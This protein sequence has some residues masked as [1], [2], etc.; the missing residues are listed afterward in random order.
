MRLLH[1]PLLVARAGGT[2]AE[3][4]LDALATHDGYFSVLVPLPATP[5]DVALPFGREHA[6]LQ[7]HS[8]TMVPI[9]EGRAMERHEADAM[10]LLMADGVVDH[11]AGL[12]NFEHENAMLMFPTESFPNEGRMALRLSFRPVTSRHAADA[13]ATAADRASCGDATQTPAAVA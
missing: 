9:S 1:V 13:V 7:L 10:H 3:L 2:H 8:A 4:Q 6:W 12:L 5:T 11:G